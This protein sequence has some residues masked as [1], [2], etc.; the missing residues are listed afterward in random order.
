MHCMKTH[1]ADVG[2]GEGTRSSGDLLQHSRG[3]GAAEHGQLPHCPVAVVVV[4]LQAQP[5]RRV[6]RHC[7]IVEPEVAAAVAEL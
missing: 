1:Q 3:V 6:Q 5:G 4:V 2:S 7:T